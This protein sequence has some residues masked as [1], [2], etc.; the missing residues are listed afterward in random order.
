MTSSTFP[1]SSSP[2]PYDSHARLYPDDNSSHLKFREFRRIEDTPGGLPAGPV[3]AYQLQQGQ[4]FQ[5]QFQHQQ[6]KQQRPWARP[7]SDSMERLTDVM[8]G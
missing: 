8:S 4:Q 6:S 3:P 5:D 2:Y 7:R 1:S